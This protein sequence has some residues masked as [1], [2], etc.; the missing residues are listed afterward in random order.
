MI[1]KE[2]EEPQPLVIIGVHNLLFLFKMFPD[3]TLKETVYY[4][5]YQGVRFISLD[6]NKAKKYRFL[7]LEK[8]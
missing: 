4:I 1:A 8:Y 2:I 5:D 3:E 6:S 7:G